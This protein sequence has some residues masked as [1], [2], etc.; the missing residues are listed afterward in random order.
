MSFAE[1]FINSNCT[2]NAGLNRKEKVKCI[3]VVMFLLCYY[4]PAELGVRVGPVTFW[5]V[6][7]CIMICLA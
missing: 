5:Y 6:D 3:V 4:G 2:D 7:V 1:L